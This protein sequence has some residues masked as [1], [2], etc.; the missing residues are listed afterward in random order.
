MYRVRRSRFLS[1]VARTNLELRRADV[2]DVGS[3]TGFYLDLWRHLGVASVTGSD[4][5]EAAFERLRATRPWARF[6][7]FDIGGDAVPFADASFD[8]ISIMDVFF[9]VVDDANFGRAI[10]NVARLLR[11]GGTL[12]FSDAMLRTSPPQ[13]SART[14]EHVVRRS[15]AAVREVLAAHGLEIVDRRPM[16]VLMAAPLDSGGSVRGGLWAVVRS[17]ASLGEV[18]S[19]LMG[20][21]LYPVERTLLSVAREGPSVKLATATLR[22][23]SR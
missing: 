6:E 18:G 15:L 19:W 16:F 11:P 1:Q 9:H 12:I 20:A 13:G 23:E 22:N 21:L 5:T 4:L 17:V 10:A 14:P 7:R 3:G 8:A 2:L